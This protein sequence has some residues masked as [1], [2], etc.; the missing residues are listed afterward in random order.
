MKCC[1]FQE[2]DRKHKED[3]TASQSD[4]SQCPN[5][6]TVGGFTDRTVVSEKDL[7]AGGQPLL[8]PPPTSADSSAVTMPLPNFAVNDAASTSTKPGVVAFPGQAIKVLV[9]TLPGLTGIPMTTP[10][11]YR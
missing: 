3:D 1:V 10:D 9:P 11:N 5:Q 8:Q 2:K 7:A 4:G 6:T